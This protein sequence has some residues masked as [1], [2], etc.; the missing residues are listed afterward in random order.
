VPEFAY[1]SCA[2]TYRKDDDGPNLHRGS[3]TAAHRKR[4]TASLDDRPM[5]QPG[6]CSQ[7]PLGAKSAALPRSLSLLHATLY[8][9]GVTIGAG[10]YVL[11]GTAAARAGMH[12]PWAFVLA[13]VLM[14]LSAA[15][16]AELAGRFP[17]AAG[18]AAY[19]RE[20]F[21]S[22]KL[23]MAVG[24]LVVAIAIVSGAAI[25]VGSAGYLAVF[26]PLPAFVLVT[27]VVLTMAAIA[28]W[29]VKESV[30][31]AGAM[32]VMEVGGLVLLIGIGLATQSDVIARLP[33]SLP[34]A[35][36]E[37]LFAGLVS[38]TLLAVFAF[39]GF[40]GLANIAEEVRDPQR[41]LPRAIF[42]TLLYVAVVWISLVSV[43]ELDLARSEAPL[44]LVFERL[45]GA[46]PKTMS[47]IAVIAT[48]NGIIVQ[49]IMAS[50]VL[51]GLAQQG[52]LPAVLAR[53]NPTTRTPLIATA[54]TTAGV[55]LMALALPLHDLADVTSRL[56]LIVFTVV[57]LSLVRIKQRESTA[58]DGSFVA[59]FWVPC[60]GAGASILLLS[61]DAITTL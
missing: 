25:A 49:I 9:L 43:G 7:Q 42:I 35:A 60:A 6:A 30:S 56:T 57:N 52:E 26:I 38:T 2:L 24:L 45:T 51:Y 21:R 5:T 37:A 40:E 14:S 28:A 27:G 34:S 1:H 54:L 12:A 3:A 32:T 18:E 19:A 47:L 41:N 48:L 16:F 29:G 36:N 50:R 39:I 8:G 13:A 61:L 20:A 58:P 15:S 46:S 10:I 59:P 4:R 44:A 23:T 17:V 53:V 33:E 22:H 31:F 55:L 11:V